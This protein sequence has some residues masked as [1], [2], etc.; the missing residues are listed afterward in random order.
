[1]TKKTEIIFDSDSNS[2]FYN[3]IAMTEQKLKAQKAISPQLKVI[4]PNKA[5]I[6]ILSLLL[7]IW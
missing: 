6:Y 1:M 2:D 5:N 3:S 7:S 4:R